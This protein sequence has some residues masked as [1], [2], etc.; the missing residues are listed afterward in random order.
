MSE[1]HL[2]MAQRLSALVM[3][4]FVIVH[5]GVMIYAIQGGLSAAEILGRTQ[6]SVFWFAFYGMFVVAVSIH[7]AIGLRTILGEWAGLRGGM[8]DWL[9]A[10]IGL[11]LFALGSQAVWAVTA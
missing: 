6:G 2:Y 8:R 9:S 1:F 10:V 7:A 4:P 3:A 11:G 5:I